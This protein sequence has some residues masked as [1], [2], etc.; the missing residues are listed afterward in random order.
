M[1][2]MI[3]DKKKGLDFIPIRVHPRHPRLNS[4]LSIAGATSHGLI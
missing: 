1:A 4:F 3:A 2:R